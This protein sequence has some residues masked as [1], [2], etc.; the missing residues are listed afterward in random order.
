[1]LKKRILQDILHTVVVIVPTD[2]PTAGHCIDVHYEPVMLSDLVLSKEHNGHR[3]R[4]HF[5]GFQSDGDT[6]RD[7]FTAHYN[8][9]NPEYQELCHVVKSLPKE[10]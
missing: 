10:H 8:N 1:M 3:M 9:I 6:G 5:R 4:R 2:F 7:K